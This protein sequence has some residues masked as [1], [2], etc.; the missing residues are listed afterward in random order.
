MLDVRSQQG[1]FGQDYIRALASA[2]GLLVHQ[3]DPDRVGIDLGFRF[4]GRPGGLASP[5]LEVQVKTWPAPERT[6]AE[7]SYDGLTEQQ[8][9]WLAGP[10]YTVP[11]YLFLLPVPPRAAEY[12]GFESGGMTL[13]HL[14][15]YRSLEDETPIDDP[16]PTRPRPVSV[17]V[18]NVLTVRSLLSLLD[19]APVGA[20]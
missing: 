7:W 3:Y 14:A 16:S 10:D 15:Y 1:K 6:G 19:P 2:A 4:P 17:P 11:R 13:R 12:A 8:F 20:G 5:A 18:G 9:N